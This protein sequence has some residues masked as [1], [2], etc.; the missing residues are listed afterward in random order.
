LLSDTR[1]ELFA[2]EFEGLLIATEYDPLTIIERLSPYLAGSASVVVHSPFSQISVDLQAKLRNIP[3]FLCPTVTETWLR[4]YQV[5][6]GRTH[7]MMAM[8]GSGGFLVHAT[9]I[10]DD[11]TAEAALMQR[12]QKHKRPKLDSVVPTNGLSTQ[13]THS[14]N[15]PKMKLEDVEMTNDNTG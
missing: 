6:P 1:E 5:L 2:G 12:R 9:K 7:P 14:S 4:R 13:S 3:H 11:P 8:S 15:E 10:Y